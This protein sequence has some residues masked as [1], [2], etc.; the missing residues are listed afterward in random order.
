MFDVSLNKLF[1]TINCIIIFICAAIVAAVACAAFAWRY[2]TFPE[3]LHHVTTPFNGVDHQI[4]WRYCSTLLY[5][6]LCFA[7]PYLE[8]LR[9]KSIRG[10]KI[11]N[12]IV[13][14]LTLSSLLYFFVFRVYGISNVITSFFTEKS[15]FIEENYIYPESKKIEFKGKRNLIHIYIESLETSFSDNK[16]HGNLIPNLFNLAKG[17]GLIFQEM[18]VH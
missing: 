16:Q 2:L 5:F 3:I 12:T 10:I 11:H 8:I 1:V 13:F 7:L 6:S 17:G 9:R 4:L 18:V 15:K 14:V